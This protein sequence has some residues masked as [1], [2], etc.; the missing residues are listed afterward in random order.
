ME[1]IY[2]NAPKGCIDKSQEYFDIAL[3]VVK[4]CFRKLK[5]DFDKVQIFGYSTPDTNVVEFV[6]IPAVEE[7]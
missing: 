6:Y 2:I 1:V 7:A 3:D 4:K 5:I